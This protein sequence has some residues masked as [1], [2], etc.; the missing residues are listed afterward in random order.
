VSLMVCGSL[1]V[2]RYQGAESPK[3]AA[4]SILIR[5]HPETCSLRSAQLDS[6]V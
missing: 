4:S 2:E 1:M 6:E 3:I 5:G